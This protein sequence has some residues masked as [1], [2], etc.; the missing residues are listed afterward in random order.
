ME[1]KNSTA[2]SLVRRRGSKGAQS[3]K[4]KD[5]SASKRLRSGRQIEKTT[6]NPA[7]DTSDN[8]LAALLKRL[9]ST[10]DTNEIRRLSDQI[11]RVVFHKQFTNA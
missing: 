2:V 4:K 3:A 6:A 9:K 5:M 8:A 11:E 7:V 10:V 1:R